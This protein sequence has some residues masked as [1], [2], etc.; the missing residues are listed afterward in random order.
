MFSISIF[1]HLISCLF[2]CT[3]CFFFI[4]EANSST[5]SF[6]DKSL[7]SNPILGYLPVCTRNGDCFVVV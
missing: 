4:Q 7:D 5:D 2:K 3:E 1:L 6:F